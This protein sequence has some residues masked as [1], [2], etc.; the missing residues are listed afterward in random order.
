MQTFLEIVVLLEKLLLSEKYDLILCH[1][2]L[3]SDTSLGFNS[4]NCYFLDSLQ[5][6]LQR[7]VLQVFEI[8]KFLPSV[9]LVLMFYF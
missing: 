8:H 2:F 7:Q 6:S 4:E 9:I 3:M 1:N 5:S